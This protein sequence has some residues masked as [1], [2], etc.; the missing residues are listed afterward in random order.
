M[1]SRF[2]AG[3]SRI[4][5]VDEFVAGDEPGAVIQFNPNHHRLSQ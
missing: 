1:L 4:V 3:K 2:N 5:A